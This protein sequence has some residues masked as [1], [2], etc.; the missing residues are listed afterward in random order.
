MAST[1]RNTN[2]LLGLKDQEIFLQQQALLAYQNMYLAQIAQVEQN[3]RRMQL[4]AIIGAPPGLG[5]EDAKRSEKNA[6]SDFDHSTSCSSPRSSLVSDGE[7][8]KNSDAT[9]TETPRMGSNDEKTT[10]TIRNLSGCTREML[11]NFLDQHG[12]RGT[13][14]LVY[15]PLYFRNRKCFPYA[16]VNFSSE[17]IALRFQACV[18]G[19]SDVSMFG[20]KL[21]EVS[22]SECQG[23]QANIENYRNSG[24]NHPSVEDEFKP[25]LFEDGETIPFPQPTKPVSENRKSRK[26]KQ[27]LGKTN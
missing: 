10:V 1:L 24:I 26:S 13:Y 2:Q 19:M 18:Q 5:C 8:E 9:D 3:M 20:D 12:F 25:M 7:S 11:L 15:L 17:R 22:W 4:F 14:D 27:T 21:A 23:L 6:Q 16:F